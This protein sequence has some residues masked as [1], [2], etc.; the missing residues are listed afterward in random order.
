M[1]KIKHCNKSF[2]TK[3]SQHEAKYHALKNINLEIKRGEFVILLGSSGCGKTTLLNI[4]GGFEGFD[5]GEISIDSEVFHKQTNP[6][7]CIKIFQ[8]FALLPWR[9]ALDNIAFGLQSKG[10]SLKESRGKAREYLKL[11]HLESLS[12]SFPINLSGGQKQRIALARGLCVKPKILLLDEPF[13]ALDNFTRISLQNELLR[14]SKELKTTMIFVTHDIEEAIFLGD[15]VIIMKPNPGQIVADI[16]IKIDKSD[17]NSLEF[18]GLKRK[19]AQYL[20]DY[21]FDLEYV[22]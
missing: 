2:H 10:F 22:I 7:D 19:I 20:E 3:K 8:D 14:I 1:I 11:V 4:I 18:L 17:R 15:R 12:H 13:S 9:N 16:E 6:K 21:R 5:S